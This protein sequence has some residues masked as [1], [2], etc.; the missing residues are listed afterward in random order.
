VKYPKFHYQHALD[1]IRLRAT[2]LAAK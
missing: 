2:A 1:Q